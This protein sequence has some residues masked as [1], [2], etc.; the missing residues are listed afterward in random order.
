MENFSFGTGHVAL[1]FAGIRKQVMF[2]VIL[3][4]AIWLNP[5]ETVD[6]AR[7]TN[8]IGR[9]FLAAHWSDPDFESNESAFYYVR[10]LEIPTPT[11]LAYDKAFYGDTI[12]LP[13]DALLVHQE[14]AYTSPI[15]YTP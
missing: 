3:H 2:I 7:F 14:R 5:Q 1:I 6:G 11:W 13:K 8:D 10:V 15:W 9:A 4:N 12:E